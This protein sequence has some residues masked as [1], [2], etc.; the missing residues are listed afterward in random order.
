MRRWKS[1]LNHKRRGKSEKA[2][3]FL[4]KWIKGLRFR[5]P[6]QWVFPFWSR[7]EINRKFCM[8]FPN[9]SKSLLRRNKRCCV[10]YLNN[11]S[12]VL[13]GTE[14]RRGDPFSSLSKSQSWHSW[15]SANAFDPDGVSVGAQIFLH[16]VP[17]C[18]FLSVVIIS[19]PCLMQPPRAASF[20]ESVIGRES[21]EGRISRSEWRTSL[22]AI[23]SQWS[24]FKLH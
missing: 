1:H 7:V 24:R 5:P 6:G 16:S 8:S 9:E 14:Q 10:Y 4:L 18:N 20:Y 22:P 15:A 12:K 21:P 19:S 2:G 17:D 13:R 11:F 23:T 3:E